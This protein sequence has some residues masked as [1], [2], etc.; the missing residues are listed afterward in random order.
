MTKTKLYGY[1]R[2]QSVFK[3]LV[4]AFVLLTMSPLM[5]LA[6]TAHSKYT[7]IVTTKISAYSSGLL[8]QSGKNINNE[9]YRLE[10]DI[11]ALAYKDTI[12]EYLLGY[13]YFSTAQRYSET[14]AVSS[15]VTNRIGMLHYISDIAFSTNDKRNF[16]IIYGGN[17]KRFT[18]NDPAIEQAFEHAIKNK[19]E[20]AYTTVYEYQPQPP[21]IFETAAKPNFE[22]SGIL[23]SKQIIDPETHII[24]GYVFIRIDESYLSALYAD[25]NLG[26][27]ST[28][29]VVDSNNNILSSTDK[30]LIGSSFYDPKLIE[31]LKNSQGHSGITGVIGPVENRNYLCSYYPIST[32]GLYAVAMIPTDYLKNEAFSISIVIFIVGII[33]FL[34]AIGFS[35]LITGSIAYPLKKITE[36]M[37]DVRDGQLTPRPEDP[38]NDEIAVVHNSFQHTIKRLAS[39]IEAI[40]DNEK[41]KMQLELKAL[42]AQINPHFLHNTLN[43]IKLLAHL[44]NVPNVESMVGSLSNILLKAIGKDNGN[45]TLHEEV[46]L[47]KDYISLHKFKHYDNIQ[48]IFSIDNS[49]INCSIPS[50]T[51]QPILEN[52]IIH[53]FPGKHPFAQVVIK[54]YRNGDE[55]V[56][57]ITDNGVGISSQKLDTIL[58]S[59]ESSEAVTTH[60]G[61]QN[62]DR[63]L[64]L[65]FGDVY[66]I[67][68]NSVAGMFTET[69]ITIPYTE[70]CKDDSNFTHR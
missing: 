41:E 35:F 54:A 10:N 23:F 29:Y 53:G 40:K 16:I 49:A 50:F 28:I 33:C 26:D 2:G 15:Y 68:I 48:Y 56:I 42:T 44:Q 20:T 38:C 25:M 32:L 52:C 5:I 22:E 6:F 43:S 3:R 27:E 58:D 66:G 39:S 63:R 18:L 4:I 45:T 1:I 11:V 12:K 61:L 36:Q 47:L 19:G 14:M 69:T 62:V 70:V 67:S 59:L 31:K 64:K 65:M 17:S 57:I 9:F 30:N 21:S 8:N 13:S 46:S 34:V 60:I 55:V 37:Q 7:S 24:L 51:L